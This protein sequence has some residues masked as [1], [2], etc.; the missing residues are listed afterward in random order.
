MMTLRL[1]GLFVGTQ[2]FGSVPF[3]QLHR[4][5][6]L[7]G[8]EGAVIAQHV[9]RAWQV[10]DQSYPSLEIEHEKLY[11]VFCD[12]E[13]VHGAQRVVGPFRTLRMSDG[14]LY[15][16]GKHLAAFDE[17]R[18]VWCEHEREECWPA[19]ELRTEPSTSES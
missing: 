13:T 16:D 11:A 6:L 4:D 2:E 1:V 5:Q 8:P 18:R 10:G 19:I 7:Q 3:C 12:P 15:G 17:A 14:Y 9:R